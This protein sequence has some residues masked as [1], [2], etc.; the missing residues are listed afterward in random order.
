[1]NT[2]FDN[3]FCSAY[4][5]VVSSRYVMLSVRVGDTVGWIHSY[6]QYLETHSIFVNFIKFRMLVIDR[7]FYVLKG[8]FPQYLYLEVL[9]FKSAQ[10]V[11]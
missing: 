5:Q 2:I 8:L 3:F 4:L 6:L 10:G 1:M 11:E 7:I 9:T